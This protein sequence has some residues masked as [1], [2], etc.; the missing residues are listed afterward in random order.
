MIQLVIAP[1]TVGDL[2]RGR[3]GLYGLGAG[4]HASNG[5]ARSEPD[6]RYAAKGQRLELLLEDLVLF[7]IADVDADDSVDSAQGGGGLDGAWS[8]EGE[9]DGDEANV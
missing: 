9:S 8:G 3:V 5:M 2:D 4:M 1:M 6:D 7:V